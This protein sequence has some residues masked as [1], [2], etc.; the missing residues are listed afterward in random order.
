MMHITNTE[1]SAGRPYR[2]EL[3]ARQAE[4]TRSAILEAAVRVSARGVATVS[5]PEIAQEARVS[6]PT[7]YRYFGT[8]QELLD[9]IYPHLERRAGRGALAVPTTIADLR[10]GVLR[11]IDQL[12]SFDDL[13]RA[14]MAS[15]AAA[16][17]RHRS[18]PRRV[19]L[20]ETMVD[21]IEPPLPREAR[22]RL[23]RLIVILTSSQSLRTWT[24]HLGS[25]PDGVADEIQAIVQAVIAA[26]RKPGR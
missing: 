8:K 24:D 13:A 15:P 21:T 16:E 5:I 11:V 1:A 26:A 18:M 14:A 25:S 3:R 12:D 7:V 10:V 17:G 4:E 9:A 2:S 6:V 20:V 19:A 22:D 23:V